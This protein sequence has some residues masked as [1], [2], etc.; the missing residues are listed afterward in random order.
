[1][2]ATGS[3]VNAGSI[4]VPTGRVETEESR[5]SVRFTQRQGHPAGL[6]LVVANYSSDATSTASR[7]HRP[8]PD[9]V[10]IARI[11]ELSVA[12]GVRNSASGSSI[13]PTR[14]TSFWLDWRPKTE[15]FGSAL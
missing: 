13:R 6:P 15:D 8:E 14:A 3:V 2:A 7:C 5:A 12:A 4:C 11:L 9:I 10:Q 1:M